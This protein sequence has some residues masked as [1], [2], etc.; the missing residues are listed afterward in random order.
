MSGPPPTA[1]PLR[2]SWLPTRGKAC[3]RRPAAAAAPPLPL[4]ASCARCRPPP[5]GA[6]AAGRARAGV[7]PRRRPVTGGA[8][9][10]APP[11]RRRPRRRTAQRR[12]SASAAAARSP[13]WGCHAP[14]PRCCTAGCW[15]CLGWWGRQRAVEGAGGRGTGARRRKGA[16]CGA[17]G[18]RRLGPGPPP[19]PG[20][21]APC[22]PGCKPPG[23]PSG[24]PKPLDR[25]P[26]Q[27]A[28]PRQ[29]GGEI[30]RGLK[31]GERLDRLE[32]RCSGREVGQGAGE[33]RG[34]AGAPG[35]LASPRNALPRPA[36]PVGTAHQRLRAGL[37]G[38]S[39]WPSA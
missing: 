27:L 12:A 3:R 14:C 35:A 19:L 16:A 33:A 30:D 18:L 28:E 4:P 25:S 34:L 36:G 5:A 23:R 39:R 2:Y 20:H 17:P 6:A 37:S 9:A 22:K 38:S 8:A 24:R 11:A 7:A 29:L 21:P 32:G 15:T 26:L 1:P 31:V 10:R 13:R